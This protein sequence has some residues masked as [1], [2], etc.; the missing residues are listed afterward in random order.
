[1][2]R[3]VSDK[4]WRTYTKR[5]E[6]QRDAAWQDAYDWVMRHGERVPMDRCKRMM[7]EASVHHGRSTSAL[8]ATYFD[9]MARAEGAEGVKAIAVNDAVQD[10][11]KRLSIAANKSL[12]KLSAGDTEGFA[13]AIAAAVAADVKRQATNTT[14]FNAAKYGAEFAWIPGGD[15]TCAFCITLASNG[16]QRASKETAMGQHAEHIHDNCMCE[17]AIRFDKSTEYAGYNAEKYEQIYEDAD[18]RSSQ[19]KVNSIRRDLYAENGDKIREQ[20]RERYA[21]LNQ[22]GE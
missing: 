21:A 7:V 3:R 22:A 15:E 17:F 5:L 14:V 4:A 11:A 16:W 6:K 20:H 2:A 12:P 13:K 9:Q 1:M 18:G 8:A 19:D 10:R